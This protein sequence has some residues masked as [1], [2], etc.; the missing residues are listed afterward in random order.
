MHCKPEQ[1]DG[2]AERL[3]ATH[4]VASAA[5]SFMYASIGGLRLDHWRQSAT[6]TES[7]DVAY[8]MMNIRPFLGA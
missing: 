1:R 7:I 4:L 8:L 5:I 2:E 3:A 6:P